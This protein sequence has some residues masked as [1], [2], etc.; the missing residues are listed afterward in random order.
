M[1]VSLAFSMPTLSTRQR[2]TQ[3]A[4]ELFLSQ[5]ISQTTTRQI[6]DK[7]GVNEVTLFRNFGNKYGLLL[8]ML[9][10][11]SAVLAEPALLPSAQSPEALRAY[12]SACLHRLERVPN[13]VRSVIGEADQYPPEHRQALQQQ[14]SEV[15]RDMAKHLDQLVGAEAARLPAGD[16]ASLLGALLVGYTVVEATSGCVLWENRE[17]FL[18]AL[19][20]VLTEGTG[21]IA[22]DRAVGEV[23][24]DATPAPRSHPTKEIAD[25]GQS[26]STQLAALIVDLPT[27][28]V[29]QMIKQ[30]RTLSPQ[31]YA[32]AYVLFGAGLL[33]EEIVRLERCHEICDKSQH[34]LQVTGPSSPRQVPVNQWILGKRY[35]SYTSNPLTKWLKTRKDNAAAM[36]INEAGEPMTVSNIQVRWDLWWQG[37]DVGGM[38]PYPNQARQTWCI[39]MLMRGISL[40]NLSILTGCEVSELSPYAQRAREKAAIAAATQLDRKAP[41]NPG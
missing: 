18:D 34:V 19:V 24:S 31:D 22:S 39:E 21:S 16:L 17:D 1:Q 12:A 5:G 30:A 28:W 33:S 15:K 9:Q 8:A 32:L 25:T 36:F 14:L 7:A 23:T 20:T 3:A 26:Q 4:L 13:F 38:R 6:A 40:E 27:A 37:I 29:H 41:A 2:L 35:G 11:A 10:E